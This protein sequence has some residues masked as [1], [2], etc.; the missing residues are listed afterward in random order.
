VNYQEKVSTRAE[1]RD[2]YERVVKDPTVARYRGYTETNSYGWNAQAGDYFK[3]EGEVWF[4]NPGYVPAESEPVCEDT[5]PDELLEKQTELERLSAEKNEL[6]ALI[7]A[8][9][10]RIEACE[11]QLRSVTEERDEALAALAALREALAAIR[12]LTEI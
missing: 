3:R 11:E 6:C 1:V 2:L 10:E 4:D 7:D 12:K 9:N 8:L 5:V